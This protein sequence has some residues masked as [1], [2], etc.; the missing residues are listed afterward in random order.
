MPLERKVTQQVS[1][2]SKGRH[3][4]A[5]GRYRLSAREACSLRDLRD[6]ILGVVM[7]RERKCRVWVLVLVRRIGLKLGFGVDGRELVGRL[8]V[9]ASWS[10]HFRGDRWHWTVRP[11]GQI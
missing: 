2:R 3:Q 5:A 7:G 11:P 6:R 1:L 8:R 4:W 10:S 9:E